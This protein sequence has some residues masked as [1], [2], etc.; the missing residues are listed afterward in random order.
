MQVRKQHLELDMEQQTGSK[1]PNG[2]TLYFMSTSNVVV[3]RQ[4]VSQKNVG[5][6]TDIHVC[7]L[8]TDLPL[9]KPIWRSGSNS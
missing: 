4:V 9:V 5:Y 7:V 1:V 8:D 6:D 2:A 3:A